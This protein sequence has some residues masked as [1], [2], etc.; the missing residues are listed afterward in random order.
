MHMM[1]YIALVLE[2]LTNSGDILKHGTIL[3]LKEVSLLATD[4]DASVFFEQLGNLVFIYFRHH[5]TL[6]TL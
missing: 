4:G 2:A 3:I 6:F 5:S 1:H